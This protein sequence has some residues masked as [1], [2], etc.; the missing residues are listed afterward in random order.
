MGVDTMSEKITVC[1]IE[2]DK[3]LNDWANHVMDCI[4]NKSLAEAGKELASLVT[5]MIQAEEYGPFV[6][7]THTC[8]NAFWVKCHNESKDTTQ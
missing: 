7:D 5:Y 1:G 2:F 8:V 3:P 6:V 4:E